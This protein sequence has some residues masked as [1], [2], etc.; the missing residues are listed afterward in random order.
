MATVAEPIA[1]RTVAASSH[2]SSNGERCAPIA[3]ATVAWAAP[4]SL[5]IRR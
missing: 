3:S 5:R 4:E 2:A 1:R